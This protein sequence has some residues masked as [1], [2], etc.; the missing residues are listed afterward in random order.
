MPGLHSAAMPQTEQTATLRLE[1]PQHVLTE[2]EGWSRS[3][4]SRS[5]QE[6]VE[7]LLAALCFNGELRE[8]ATRLIQD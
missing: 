8:V 5:A 1:L 3:E 4:L 6:A 7:D 2:L